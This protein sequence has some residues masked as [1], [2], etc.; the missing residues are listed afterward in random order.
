MATFEILDQ[1][2]KVADSSRLQDCMKVWFVQKRAEEKAFAG[3]LRDQCVGLRMTNS[4]NQMLIAKLE[5][6]GERG[7]VVRCLD[8]MREIVARDSV[9]LRVLEQ[10][11]VGTHVGIGLKDSYVADMEENEYGF[12]SPGILLLLSFHG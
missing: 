12:M 4:K 2:T 1:L 3:F 11:L 9:K 5:A 10:L 8:H 6:L 7:D